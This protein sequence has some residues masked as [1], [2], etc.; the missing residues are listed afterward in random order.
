MTSIRL[1]D[2]RSLNFCHKKDRFNV[3]VRTAYCADDLTC[4]CDSA[5]IAEAYVR[6]RSNAEINCNDEDAAVLMFPPGSRRRCG[7]ICYRSVDNKDSQ[8]TSYAITRDM[9]DALFH[10]SPMFSPGVESE[11]ALAMTRIGSISLPMEYLS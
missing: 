7:G 3:S 11:L 1:A 9:Q 4:A 6:E 2:R 8:G 5:N 10:A